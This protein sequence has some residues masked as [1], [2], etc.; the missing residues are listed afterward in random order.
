MPRFKKGNTPGPGRPRGSRNKA[1][2]LLEQLAADGT[3][4]V[5]RAVMQGVK[6]RNMRA[7]AIAAAR[8]WP[9]PRGRVVAIDL[10][11]VETAAGVVQAQAAVVAAMAAG[12]LSPE[13]AAEIVT[14]LD[15]QCRAI[16]AHVNEQRIDA[17]EQERRREQEQKRK[18]APEWDDGMPPDGMLA[19]PD[20]P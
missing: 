19:P 15:A 4:Q 10:P 16:Q 13:E 20:E 7:V 11:A 17:L 8:L 1:T 14:V 5:V 6:D 12:E 3:E 9:R 2:I 18:P